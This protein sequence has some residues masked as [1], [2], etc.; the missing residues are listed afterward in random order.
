MQKKCVGIWW[1]CKSNGMKL[2][3]SAVELVT[4]FKEDVYK[5]FEDHL[6]Q[7]SSISNNILPDRYFK[8]FPFKSDVTLLSFPFSNY[9]FTGETANRFLI[10]NLDNFI[11]KRITAF[12]NTKWGDAQAAIRKKCMDEINNGKYGL[13]TWDGQYMYSLIGPNEES[14]DSHCKSLSK[15]FWNKDFPIFN[16]FEVGFDFNLGTGKCNLASFELSDK[17]NVSLGKA[18]VY[19]GVNY[20]GT[21]YGARIFKNSH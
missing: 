6:G 8:D 12:V 19:G 10:K 20:N 21:W 16:E 14:N 5:I 17:P 18:E 2:G 11:G 15:D 1:K 13:Y 7:I 3:W 9:T 4:D